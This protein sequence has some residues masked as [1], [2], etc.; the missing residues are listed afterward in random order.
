MVS[1]AGLRCLLQWLQL[2]CVSQDRTGTGWQNIKPLT[3]TR[4]TRTARSTFK[5]S[6]SIGKLNSRKL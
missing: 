3:A 5:V 4:F 2:V 6:K 1:S